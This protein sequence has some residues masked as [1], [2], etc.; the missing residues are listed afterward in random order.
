MNLYDVYALFPVNIV[1][2][3]SFYVWDDE[4]N[5]YLDLYGGHAVISIGH[6]HPH[7]VEKVGK[8]L[9]TLGFY[10]NSVINRIQEELAER[11]GNISGYPDYSFF[12]VNSGAEANENALKLASFH[13]GRS[14]VISFC[15]AFHGRTSLAVEATDNPSTIL[16]ISLISASVLG[17]GIFN[18]T[19]SVLKYSFCFLTISEMAKVDFLFFLHLPMS[20][21]Y[22][23]HIYP[24]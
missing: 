11:V 24:F 2:G 19:S 8:Q 5:K 6:S 13:T 9:S 23:V 16:S 22:L 4:G 12:M 18:K 20:R 3:E 21:I 7:Y 10:S 1:R 17:S 15:K 14:R